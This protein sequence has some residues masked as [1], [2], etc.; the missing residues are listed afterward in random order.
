MLAAHAEIP[1]IIDPGATMNYPG[2]TGSI[3]VGISV[4][5]VSEAL[6]M[7]VVT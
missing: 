6:R 4:L 2:A 5:I 7:E 3:I 1:T